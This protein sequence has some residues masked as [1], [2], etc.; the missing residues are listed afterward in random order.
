MVIRGKEWDG[1][2]G[3]EVKEGLDGERDLFVGVE[4]DVLHSRLST[5]G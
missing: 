3:T 2:S 4:W 5:S 1:K